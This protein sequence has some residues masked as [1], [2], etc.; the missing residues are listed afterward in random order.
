[1]WPVNNL[2]R[3]E[4]TKAFLDPLPQPEGSYKNI[5]PSILLS[6]HPSIRSFVCPSFCLS[7]SFLR[8]GSLVFPETEHGQK[9][10]QNSVFG[11][12]KK[13]MSL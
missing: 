4:F 8:I 5:H 12:F 7:I 9:W 6:I 11:L 2:F 3:N 13:I 1:M 10:P